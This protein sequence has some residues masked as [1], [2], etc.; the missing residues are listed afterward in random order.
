[1][2][3]MCQKTGIRFIQAGG[4]V[5]DVEIDILATQGYDY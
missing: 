3:P 4:N 1:M 2:P 5:Y